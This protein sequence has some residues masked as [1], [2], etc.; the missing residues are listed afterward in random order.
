M[1]SV[2]T[3][4]GIMQTQSECPT[5]HGDG[6]IIKNK[7]QKCKGTGVIKGEEVVEIKIPAGVADGMI[8]NIPG[9]GNAGPRNGINGDIQVYISEIPEDKFIRDGNDLIYNLLLDIPTAI[10]GDTVEIPTIDG[11][12]VKVKIEPGT[13][14]GKTLRLR[15]K[16]LPAIHGYGS[17]IGDI[18]VNISVYIPQTLNKNERETIESLKESKN[19][20][21]DD[22]DKKSIFEKFRSYFN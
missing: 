10:L 1:R 11:T 3:A 4:F 15:G 13:Q 17:G 19:F 7:C 18:I 5:C 21:G 12:K 8:V 9:K 20:K 22:T 2:R 14:P 16:G 6:T